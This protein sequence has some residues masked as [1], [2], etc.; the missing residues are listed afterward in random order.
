MSRWDSTAK[1]QGR[2]RELRPES[3]W[4]GR[5]AQGCGGGGAQGA[6]GSR[7]RGPEGSGRAQAVPA[8]LPDAATFPFCRSVTS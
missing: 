6:G 5:G 1:A 4:G 2:E 3:P 7:G 8:A